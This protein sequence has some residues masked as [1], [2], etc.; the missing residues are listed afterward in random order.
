MVYEESI[1]LKHR[2]K[3]KKDTENKKLKNTKEIKINITQ[4]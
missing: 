1:R 4:H 3:N 2:Y